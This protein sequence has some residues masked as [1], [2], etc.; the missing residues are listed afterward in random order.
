MF[1]HLARGLTQLQRERIVKD[2]RIRPPKLK[3]LADISSC[4]ARL[5]RHEITFILAVRLGKR[6]ANTVCAHISFHPCDN[7]HQLATDDGAREPFVCSK[8]RGKGVAEFNRQTLLDVSAG[9]LNL[10]FFLYPVACMLLYPTVTENVAMQLERENC[11]LIVLMHVCLAYWRDGAGRDAT[12][13]LLIK[14]VVLAIIAWGLYPTLF[15]PHTTGADAPMDPAVAASETSALKHVAA[16][17]KRML[18]QLVA[19]TVSA[20]ATGICGG[21]LGF[22][23]LYGIPRRWL[24]S[25]SDSDSGPIVIQFGFPILGFCLCAMGGLIWSLI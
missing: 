12:K 17:V 6:I 11:V 21:L 24:E 7:C 15:G 13:R 18:R 14:D 5:L 3:P 16:T 23:F 22:L 19:S 2:I 4:A 10:W 8:C 20:S 9:W 1:G 25:T